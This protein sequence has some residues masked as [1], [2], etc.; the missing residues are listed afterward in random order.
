LVYQDYKGSR[1]RGTL[2]GIFVL[3]TIISLISLYAIGKFH[4]LEMKL[5][6]IL[7]PG[8][9]SGYFLSNKL[10]RI[11]DKGFIRPAVL[12]IAALSGL[13]IIVKTF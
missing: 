9:L 2:S 3:G 6:I 1:L 12:T 7:S 13:F 8:I 10:A 11:A 5:A 4:V